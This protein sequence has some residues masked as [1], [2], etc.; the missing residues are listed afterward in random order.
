M[1]NDKRELLSIDEKLRKNND[2]TKQKR[3]KNK[4]TNIPVKVRG[5]IINIL[6]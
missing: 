2:K 4:N 1:T 3:K 6:E 5:I